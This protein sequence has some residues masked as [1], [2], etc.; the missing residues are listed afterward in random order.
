MVSCEAMLDVNPAAA[1][2]KAMLPSPAVMVAVP[3]ANVLPAV[4]PSVAP[5][6]ALAA[7]AVMIDTTTAKAKPTI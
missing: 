7:P 4:A 3:A 5:M 6:A 2:D 1:A